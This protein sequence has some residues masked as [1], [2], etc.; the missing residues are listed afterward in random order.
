MILFLFLPLELLLGPDH[1]LKHTPQY[2]ISRAVSLIIFQ[3][4]VIHITSSFFLEHARPD[5]VDRADWPRT[6]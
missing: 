3:L 4:S 1:D 5:N 6:F 2:F